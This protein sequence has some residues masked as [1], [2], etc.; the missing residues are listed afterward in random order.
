MYSS[1]GNGCT[2]PLSGAPVHFVSLKAVE[3]YIPED[4]KEMLLLWDPNGSP[5]LSH[6]PA[7]YQ[8]DM[9]LVRL[10]TVQGQS[11]GIGFKFDRWLIEGG[12]TLQPGYIVLTKSFDRRYPD[13]AGAILHVSAMA[14]LCQHLVGQEPPADVAD[15]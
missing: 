15:F 12:S 7:D 3:G 13:G 14:T 2:E 9:R 10:Q 1:I 8:K 6:F 11:W 5:S 4:L